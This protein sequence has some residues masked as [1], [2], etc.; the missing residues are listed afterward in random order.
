[1]TD[2]IDRIT[3]DL[4]KNYKTKKFKDALIQADI[5]SKHKI[6]NKQINFICGELFL[7]FRLYKKALF[8]LAYSIKL[9]PDFYM[10]YKLLG[11]TEYSL[12]NFN[13]ALKIYNA[14]KKLNN[15]DADLFFNIAKSYSDLGK[16]D[17]SIKNYIKSLK[18]DPNNKETKIN[19]IKS[20]TFFKP[21]D[22]LDNEIIK[23]DLSLYN[24]ILHFSF[25][26]ILDNRTLKTYLKKNFDII[27]TKID[28]LG[29]DTTQIFRNNHD[30]L[31]CPRYH[32]AFNTYNIIPKN[33]FS[34]FKVQVNVFNVVDLIKLHFLFDNITFVKNIKKCMV[35]KRKDID[36]NYKGFIYCKTVDEAEAL[37]VQIDQ[38]IN[39]SLK[40]DHKTIVKRGCS[41]FTLKYPDYKITDSKSKSFF[42]YNDDW[43]KKENIINEF[44]PK[45]ISSELN[46]HDT[47]KGNSL[48][49]MITI[50]NWINYAESVNDYSFK[51]LT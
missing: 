31:D 28:N 46:P 21:K 37:K 3:N 14:A 49:D 33:C 9:D 47:L 30:P 42:K 16:Y 27:K 11:I 50:K 5:L 32:T 48:N 19:L 51:K 8:S 26:K 12:G 29:F 25:S 20:L 17:L 22:H 4:I 24:L 7:F 41:E 43:H 18:L 13:K 39:K 15:H 23:L 2:N 1:M 36:G 44:Y 6:K 40:I 38:L 34:C 10:A 45:N 35:E